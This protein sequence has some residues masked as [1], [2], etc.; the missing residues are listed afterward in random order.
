[1]YA[2]CLSLLP[3]IWHAGGIVLRAIE[4]GKEKDQGMSGTMA[5]SYA[6][7]LAMHDDNHSHS[8]HDGPRPSHVRSSPQ[9]V[10]LQPTSMNGGGP[11]LNAEY[12][13]A[14]PVKSYAYTHVNHSIPNLQ[15]SLEN[16]H[17]HEHKQLDQH[18]QPSQFLKPNLSF[19]NP[20]QGRSKSMER[21]RSVGLPT[22]LQL[23]DSGYG[24][25]AVSTQKFVPI[26]EASN[27]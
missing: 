8:H 18:S 19:S 20:T 16:S 23:K 4:P 2:P 17:H 15:S 5:A 25:Q 13:S 11:P 21:R 26:E 27:R 6:L 22:H 14:S 1:M 24:F 7:P 10:P 12:Q 9:R 3:H